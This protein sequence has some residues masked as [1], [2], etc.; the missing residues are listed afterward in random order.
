MAKRALVVGINDYSNWNNGATV[1]GLVLTAPNLSCDIAD[2]T[3]FAQLLNDAF[4]FDSVTALQ[5]S[6]AT[7]QAILSGMKSILS[8]SQAGDVVCFY[9]SGH[10]ARLA[11]DPNSASPRYY[12]AIVPYDANL[13][14]SAQVASI[15]QSLPPS[16]INFT[17][18]LDACH[19]GGMFLSPDM[20]GIAWDKG[21]AAA[22]QATCCAIVPWIC[23]LDPT[24][25]DNNVSDLNLL[26]SRLCSM[27]HDSSKD[28]P[29]EAKAT[30]LSACD[31]DEVAG[32][33]S[34]QG[35]S[36]F[37]QAILDAVNQSNFQISHPDLLA[38]VRQKISTYPGSN[39]APQLRGRPI[40][41][42]ENFLNGWNYNV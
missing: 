19:S 31:Y 7:A 34:G 39:Q 2:A 9:F 16:E 13:V 28:N 38:A 11:E 20:K 25:I 18:V 12:E 26:P 32:A 35:H 15:A 8:N 30:L 22:F 27:T 17:L 33:A 42:E 4:L 37:T 6:Q 29:D 41:L 23:L 1:N 3:D 24:A 10:G 5:D 40:R 21:A 36:T 14:T